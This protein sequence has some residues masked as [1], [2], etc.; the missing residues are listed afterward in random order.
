MTASP[1]LTDVNL[2]DEELEEALSQRSAATKQLLQRLQAIHPSSNPEQS[3]KVDELETKCRELLDQV[4]LT[5]TDRQPLLLNQ[6][7]ISDFLRD[8]PFAHE[9]LYD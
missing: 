8:S 9:K 6:K 2:N 5:F 4:R 1:P 7:L 3:S